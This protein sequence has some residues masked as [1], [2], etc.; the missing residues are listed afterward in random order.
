MENRP[1]P[2]LTKRVIHGP[3]QLRQGIERLQSQIGELEA[4]DCSSVKARHAT[5]TLAIQAAIAEMLAKTFGQ[6]TPTYNLYAPAARL[7][8]GPMY[9]S[10]RPPTELVVEWIQD[11]KVKSLELL[12]QAVK[13]LQ[14]DLAALGEK[15][16][17]QAPAGE[18]APSNVASD[19]RDR[20]RQRGKDALCAPTDVGR[21][22]FKEASA[23]A[24]DVAE[25]AADRFQDKAE[26]QQRSG[27]DFIGM[28]AGNMR[29]AARGI[30][31]GADYVEEAAKKIR[32]GS[33]GDLVD[34]ASDF[35]KRQP[36]AFLGLSVLVGFA[37]VRFLTA[38]R[39]TQPPRETKNKWV[40]EVGN[41]VNGHHENSRYVSS[42]SART[43]QSVHSRSEP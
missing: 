7:D 8:N 14:D 38:S 22:K 36:A 20:V 31:T 15:R 27:V 41:R 2:K 42:N 9:L 35:A 25:D 17:G 21:D 26:E 28:L 18:Q 16:G 39:D 43:S 13:D 30:N 1:P 23:T 12:K 24:A 32:N 10:G 11:G 40:G 5:E 37:A 4:F 3:D 6:G 33:F 19:D 34:G 29:Q